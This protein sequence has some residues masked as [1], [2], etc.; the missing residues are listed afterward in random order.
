MLF[1][2]LATLLTI[3]V[4]PVRAETVEQFNM[5]EGV[6]PSAGHQPPSAQAM[7]LHPCGCVVDDKGLERKAHTLSSSNNSARF[8]MH[9]SKCRVIMRL[10]PPNHLCLP[11]SAHDCNSLVQ[12]LT[13]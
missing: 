12:P 11:P 9:H 13:E 7:W 6:C 2:A 8:R 10:W 4:T 1:C 5:R 3:A